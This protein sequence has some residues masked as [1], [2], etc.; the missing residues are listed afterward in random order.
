MSTVWQY[1]TLDAPTSKTVTCNIWKE[2]I[3]RG[4]TSFANFHTSNLIKHLKTLHAKE[5]DEF[6]KAKRKKIDKLQQQTLETAFKRQDKFPKSAKKQQFI[7]M[8]DQPLSVFENVGFRHLMEH[9][10]GF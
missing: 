7:V 2:A 10:E 4:C 6:T 8:D 9:L 3:S 1:F 5:H